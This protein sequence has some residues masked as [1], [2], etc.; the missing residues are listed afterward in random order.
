MNHEREVIEN[1]SQI[2]DSTILVLKLCSPQKQSK[3]KFDPDI[4]L[5]KVDS[6]MWN[7]NRRWE[8]A[9]VWYQEEI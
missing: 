1:M 4:L 5:P 9:K 6:Y 7:P 8:W 2:E 3:A